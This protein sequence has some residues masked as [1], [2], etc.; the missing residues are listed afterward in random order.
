[1]R[2]WIPCRRAPR[3]CRTIQEWFDQIERYTEKLAEQKQQDFRETAE[4]QCPR[5]TA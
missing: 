3:Y 4:S 2:Y 1:M 5:F